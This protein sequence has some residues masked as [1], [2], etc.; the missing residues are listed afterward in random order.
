MSKIFFCFSNIPNIV[1]H[2]FSFPLFNCVEN[3]KVT[4]KVTILTSL[5]LKVSTTSLL[6]L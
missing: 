4:S 5:K 6:L 1:E 2:Y 3:E